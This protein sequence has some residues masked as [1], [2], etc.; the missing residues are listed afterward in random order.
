MAK[1]NRY[2][3]KGDSK[4][5]AVSL[6]LLAVFCLLPVVFTDTYFNMLITKFTTFCIVTAGMLLVVVYQSFRD[7]SLAGF[8]EGM[9]REARE[10]GFLSSIRKRLSPTDISVLIFALVCILSTALS[11]PYLLEALLGHEGRYNGLLLMLLY[12]GSFFAVSR[13]YRF[14]RRHMTAFMGVGLF[15][16]LFGI[17]QY[18]NINLFRFKDGL[19]SWQWDMF[20]STIGNINT[21]TAYVGYILAFSGV[22]FITTPIVSEETPR[23]ESRGRVVFYAITMAVSFCAIIMGK[24]DNAYLTIGAFFGFLP[25]GVF[26]NRR[27]IRRYLLSLAVFITIVKAITM[28]NDALPGRV[29]G[30]DGL[31]NYM[32]DFPFLW[33]IIGILYLFVFLCYLL[34]YKMKKQ[35]APVTVL[36]RI[37]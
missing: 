2:L 31:Y 29:L 28:V 36:P 1:S 33:V 37:L 17:V 20:T 4:K 22:L 3:N 14:D 9:V 34:D 23:G 27:N 19:Q 12:T 13:H 15:V 5:R 24:S 6:W 25:F 30:I 21:Y 18:F 26:T 32:A 8:F 7:R 16:C 35:N 11:Y 10:E